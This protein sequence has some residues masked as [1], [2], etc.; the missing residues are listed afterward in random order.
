M[1][2]DSL[3]FDRENPGT[4][5]GGTA[6]GGAPK[7]PLIG[8]VIGERYLVLS[9]LGTGGWGRVY[10]VEHTHLKNRLAMKVLHSR[11]AHDDDKIVRFKREAKALVALDHPHVARVSDFTVSEDGNFCLMMELLK[12]CSLATELKS[13]GALPADEV[14]DIVLQ[15]CQ[16]LSAAHEKHIVHR[17]IKPDNIWIARDPHGKPLAKVIDFGLASIR[18]DDGNASTNLT[19]TGETLGTPAYMSPE[20]CRGRS[21]DSR[22]DVYSVG[23]V[24]YEALTGQQAFVAENVLETMVKHVE[25][26]VDPLA[27]ANPALKDWT[28]LQAVMDRVL[29]IELEDRYQTVAELADDIEAL[30]AG[31]TVQKSTLLK[32]KWRKLTQRKS[33][34]I[35]VFLFGMA[36]VSLVML[37]IVLGRRFDYELWMVRILF[38]FMVWALANSVRK[39]ISRESTASQK[40]AAGFGCLSYAIIASLAFPV[41]TAGVVPVSLRQA[42]WHF[43][44]DNIMIQNTA[45]AIAAVSML[46]SFWILRR[47]AKKTSANQSQ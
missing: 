19:A 15:V 39:L 12:G 40:Q 34:T 35:L 38:L 11:H 16:G 20:Q 9:V 46:V 29:A 22:T 24:L 10:E 23:C 2:N 32:S 27:K 18:D 43:Y 8:K 33:P 30:K 47:S 17:D 42:I 45:V 3:N 26:V 44:R 25:G 41:V 5:G 14:F 36:T 13:R 31:K 1:T 21:S 6:V 7:D 4:A 28:S 37:P